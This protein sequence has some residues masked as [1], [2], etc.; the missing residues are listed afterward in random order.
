MTPEGNVMRRIMLRL[1]NVIGVVTFRNQSGMA[2]QGEVIRQDHAKGLLV[3]RNPRPVRFGCGPGGKDG[4]DLLGWVTKTVT[5]DMVGKKVAIFTA[6]EV[7]AEDGRATPGQQ[8]FVDAVN[9]AGGIAAVVRSEEE[10][11]KAVNH[12]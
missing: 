1:S 9:A 6:L 2:W 4:S 10:A 3:L 11:V 8:R 7:K 12:G 5:P